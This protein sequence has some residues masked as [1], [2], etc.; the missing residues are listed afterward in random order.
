M[1]IKNS[2]CAI[3]A[4]GSRD[5]MAMHH[6]RSFG[7]EIILGNTNLRVATPIEPSH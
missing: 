7:L 1:G 2:T 6:A 5:A 3:R 4:P